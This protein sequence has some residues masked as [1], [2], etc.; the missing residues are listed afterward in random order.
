[1]LDKN[2][3]E[4]ILFILDEESSTTSQEQLIE[5]IF[6]KMW[7]LVYNVITCDLLARMFPAVIL[8]V[9]HDYFLGLKMIY[10][11]YYAISALQ[12]LWDLYKGM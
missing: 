9:K 8:W 6:E 3:W 12:C 2:Y 5:E 11:P 4:F 10:S 1:M 7:R